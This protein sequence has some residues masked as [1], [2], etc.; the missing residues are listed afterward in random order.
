MTALAEVPPVAPSMRPDVGQSG[1][2]TPLNTPT[3]FGIEADLRGAYL[4]DGD[5]GRLAK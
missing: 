5:S 2:S 3:D 4:N 1:S